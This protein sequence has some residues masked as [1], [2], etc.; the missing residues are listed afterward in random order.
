[1]NIPT[2]AIEAA[3]KALTGDYAST[4][5]IARRVLEAAAPHMLAGAWD[6]GAIA[7]W[8]QSGEGFNAEYPDESTGECSVDLSQ[9]PHRSVQ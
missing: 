8:S 3:A 1:M 7:G 2:E 9:N 4:R 6:E 5:S